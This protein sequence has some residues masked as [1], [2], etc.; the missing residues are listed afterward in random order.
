MKKG[1]F[2]RCLAF[3]LLGC[4]LLSQ[5]SYAS[6]ADTAVAVE[7]ADTVTDAEDAVTVEEADLVSEVGSFDTWEVS[8]EE[9]QSDVYNEEYAYVGSLSPRDEEESAELVGA[10]DIEFLN[11]F[12][13]EELVGINQEAIKTDKSYSFSCAD[14]SS[15][16]A[17]YYTFTPT[18]TGS[19]R[20]DVKGNKGKFVFL[21]IK[22]T[23]S[24]AENYTNWYGKYD[25]NKLKII[26]Q[27]EK[28]TSYYFTLM[29]STNRQD[30][31][32]IK[33]YKTKKEITDGQIYVY[34]NTYLKVG[35]TGKGAWAVN[36]DGTKNFDVWL[37][38]YDEVLS[39]YWIDLQLSDGKTTENIKWYGKEGED[40]GDT[41]LFVYMK[42]LTG[43]WK[44]DK[45][46]YCTLSLGSMKSGQLQIPYYDPLFKDVR[47]ESHAYYKAIYWAA[48]R[49]ITKGYTKGADKGKFGINDTCT[50]GHAVQFLWKM[51]GSPEPKAVS[52][53][54][55]PDVPESHTYYQAVLWAQQ[56]GITKGYTKG[57]DK[58][59]F[60]INDT[61]TRGQIMS[62]IW[63][64]KKQP[65]PQIG[66]ASPF[67]D[68]P[69]SHVYYKAILW[70]S[71]NGVTKGYTTGPK[72]GQFG[73]D[74]N[75]TRGQIVKFLYNI[76]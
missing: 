48:E 16:N 32:T 12:D 20:F 42:Q 37:F 17:M 33:F 2:R 21:I 5:A 71:Q 51:A 9:P 10:D 6:E 53:T 4:M 76:R 23:D 14:N 61:C 34:L 67:S 56:N 69:T 70:G 54:P 68:V 19:Y 15:A 60:G 50:R 3:S 57:A 47:D 27:L 35:P 75:C 28:G 44:L 18:V 73:V 52:G 36:S 59:K 31:G 1:L 43:D 49:G 29:P 72:A 22:R 46:A 64:F 38:D 62:F 39:L 65:A 26:A 8:S 11:E 25:G 58:G 30:S 55:F 7:A 13:F 74:D 24:G 40:I 63:R 45:K 66:D 41:G